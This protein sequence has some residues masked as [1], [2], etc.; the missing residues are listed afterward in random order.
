[1]DFP[2][3]QLMD[4]DACFHYLLDLFHPQGLH[5]PRCQAQERFYVHRYFREPVLDY[6]CHACG[7]TFNA[8]TGTV[9]QGIHYCPSPV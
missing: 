2:I 7:R 6:R 3:Q 5:C 9:L 8:W 4:E 1:M